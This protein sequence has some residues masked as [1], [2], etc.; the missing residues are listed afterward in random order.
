MGR[1][2]TGEDEEAHWKEM[3]EAKGQTVILGYMRLK[4]KNFQK[5]V[6]VRRYVCYRLSGAYGY[7]IV[8]S[9]ESRSCRRF[10]IY[11]RVS[12]VLAI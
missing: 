3:I 9:H 5:L 7:K 11:L 8:D 12:L 2:N 10:V 4:K 1:D 6:W